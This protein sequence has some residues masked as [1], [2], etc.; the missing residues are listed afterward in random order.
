[1]ALARF[2]EFNGEW[3]KECSGPCKGAF[4]SDSLDGLRAFFPRTK[5]RKMQMQHKNAIGKGNQS[6]N[7][8][9]E[10]YTARAKLN[11][12]VSRGL[13]IKPKACSQCF[14][15]GVVHGHHKNYKKPLDVVWLCHPCH[16]EVH[17]NERI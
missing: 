11:N 9:P 2:I 6:R 12:A 10:K 14:M 4:A 1:M 17:F 7:R 8:Y 3:H 15:P 5:S 13:I 16:A